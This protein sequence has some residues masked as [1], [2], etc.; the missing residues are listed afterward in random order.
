MGAAGVSLL[1]VLVAL[2]LGLMVVSLTLSTL[3][4]VQTARA[5][6]A[7]RADALA[8][9]RMGRHVLRT[10]L[11]D[12][13]FGRDWAASSDS[14]SLRAFRGVGRVCAVDSIQPRLVVAYRGLRA[15]DPSKDSILVVTSRGQVGV[16]ALIGRS[17]A[18][19]PCAGMEAMPAE[20]WTLDRL[21]EGDVVA[22]RFFE[23]G[24]YYL[25]SS[26]LRYRRGASGRQPLTPEVLSAASGWRISG[27]RL[28]V[29]LVPS[30]RSGGWR[31]FLAWL[32]PQ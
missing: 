32:A 16:R 12:G 13:M 8:A 4:H 22:A 9:L 27:D 11:R 1:E 31:G 14:L 29:T 23:R 6:M 20:V 21:V 30:G 24:S 18:P 5:D 7:S 2:V 28:E 15:P 10:E 3:A 17:N 25:T 26:A 19:A